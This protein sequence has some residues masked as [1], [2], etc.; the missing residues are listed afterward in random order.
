[1]AELDDD[2]PRMLEFN[3]KLLKLL[4]KYVG[5]RVSENTIHDLKYQIDQERIRFQ[6]KY[7]YDIPQLVV[8]SLPTSR[9]LGLFRAYI[10]STQIQTIILN[11]LREFAVRGIP[12]DRM[13]L[14][15]AIKRTWPYYDP[16]A[17]IDMADV[18]GQAKPSMR[19]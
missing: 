4:S 11:M 9:H 8:L 10:D 13:E 5:Q 15:I 17:V 2:D 7:G 16:S 6:Q 19:N 18:D 14:A 3:D 1:M 12:V